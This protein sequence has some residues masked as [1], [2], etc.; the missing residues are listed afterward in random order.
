MI[1]SPW[2]RILAP[3]LVSVLLLVSS[4]GAP[5]P[6]SRFEQAQKESTQRGATPAVVKDAEQG[7]SFNKFFPKS[8]GGYQSVPAQEKKGF[9]EYKLNKD[10]KNVAVL[11]IS[12]TVSTPTAAQKYQQSSQKISG[13]PAVQIGKN[14][15]GVLVGRYQVKVQSRDPSFTESDREAWLQKFNLSG[16]ARLK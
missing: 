5:E 6:P 2:R 8:G 4:C 9:A 1:F 7:S 15:T 11:S 12:D 16:L 3:M 10:G 13:Y 14:G